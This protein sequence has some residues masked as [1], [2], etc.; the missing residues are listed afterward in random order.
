[1]SRVGSFWDRRRRLLIPELD[2]GNII[3]GGMGHL[4]RG[5]PPL[6][7]LVDDDPMRR[8]LRW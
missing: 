6:E 8:G 5:L 2:V 1:M 3:I 4:E 7:I